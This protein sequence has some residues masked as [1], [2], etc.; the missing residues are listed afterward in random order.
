MT[1]L[2]CGACNERYEDVCELSAH[3]KKCPAAIVL[4]PLCYK[5]SFQHIMGH[6]Y[7]GWLMYIKEARDLMRQYAL[8]ISNDLDNITRA[9]VHF[10][11]CGVLHI[12]HKEFKPFEA[13][14]IKHIPTY[15]DAKKI[16]WFALGKVIDR[17]I[18]EYK[19]KLGV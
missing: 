16:L 5:A 19:E 3:I 14:E 4:L 12:A 8:A 15:E 6:P 1:Q 17:D 7:S 13:D 2:H 9:K 11:L 18:Q 10:E